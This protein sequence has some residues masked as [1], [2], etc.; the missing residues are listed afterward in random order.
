MTRTAR[1]MI[2]ALIL[3]APL[4]STAY[5]QVYTAASCNRDDVNSLINGPTHVAVNGDTIRIPAGTCT[6]TSGI[7]VPDGL[8][9]TITGAGVPDGTPATM[10]ASASCTA[11]TLTLAGATAFRATPAYGAS[12]MRVSCLQL[13]YGSGGSVG[14]S[15][16]GRCAA[17][18]CPNLRVD[19][20]TFSD[21]A[22]HAPNRISYGIN[23]IGN[24]FGVLDHNT[25]NG[26]APTGSY[27]QLVQVSH[28]SYLGVGHYGDKAWA[29][30]EDYGTEKFLYFENNRFVNAGATEHEGSAGGLADA[31]GGRV[32]VRFN[33]FTNMDRWNFS[34][35]WHGTESYGRPRGFRTFEYYQ[36]THDCGDAEYRCAPMVAARSGT[37]L[38]WGNTSGRGNGLN[39]FLDLTTYRT[40]QNLGDWGACDGASPYDANDG[41]TYWSGTIQSVSGSNPYTI[42][43]NGSPGW[44]TNQWMVAGSAY[45]VHDAAINNGSE[46]TANGANTLTVSALTSIPYAAGHAIS[47]LRATA[48]LDQAGGRG[49]GVLYDDAN[50]ARSV[51]ANQ[52][53][54]P[55][56]VWAN[57]FGVAPYRYVKVT[58][59]TARVIRNRE[60]YVEDINQAAQS[61]S[62]FPF[63]GTTT[64]G[65]GHGTW[66]N[67]PP[68]C[69]PG[70]GYWATDQGSWNRV[71]GGSQ[72]ELY[73]CTNSGGPTAPWAI[74]YTPYAYPHP[75]IGGAPAAPTRVIIRR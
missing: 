26:G 45:S 30:P 69:T 18:G 57:T 11:T 36:N 17:S 66:A 31:G 14:L 64:L 27:L 21:W 46:I 52:V 33:E 63:D 67:R 16:L 74:A 44:R 59:A 51:A 24:M 73:L 37:G 6:W 71:D 19:N 55:T 9:I 62:T 39:S 42:T 61:T 72:G 56:Y 47:I 54:S 25:V 2:L 15:V 29:M 48:C 49:A 68:T 38:A 53:L 40:L 70:V 65:M 50:P 10:G 20:V 8:G 58:P 41:V 28:A 5:A 1:R 4:P 34:T 7:V 23:A 43:V 75:L 22:G 12:T 32:V 60:Y 13:T 3:T 35:G